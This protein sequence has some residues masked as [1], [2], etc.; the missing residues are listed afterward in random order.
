MTRAW[1]VCPFLLACAA[2]QPQLRGTSSASPGE[3]PRAA[4]PSIEQNCPPE[5]EGCPP[6]AGLAPLAATA[7]SWEYGPIPTV[8]TEP[9]IV[10]TPIVDPSQRP[11][12]PA[13]GSK[14]AQR[15]LAPADAERVGEIQNCIHV[16][17]QPESIEDPRDRQIAV[18]LCRRLLRLD[19]KASQ[20][21]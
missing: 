4:P 12:E 15:A 16:I 7:P 2:T 9:V 6:A 20:R 13:D 3:V 1:F 10:T 17:E 11:A 8:S 18:S 14:T 19:A 5:M 21:P